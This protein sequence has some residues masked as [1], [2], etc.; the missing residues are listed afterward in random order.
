VEVAQEVDALAGLHSCEDR[1][2]GVRAAC[3]SG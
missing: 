2:S 1:R 3:R